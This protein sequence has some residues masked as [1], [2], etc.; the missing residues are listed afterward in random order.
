MI[1]NKFRQAVKPRVAVF[2]GQGNTPAHFLDIRPEM[3]IIA[4]QDG[5]AQ[6]FG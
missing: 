4:I 2:I 5:S 3:K 6:A 1:R